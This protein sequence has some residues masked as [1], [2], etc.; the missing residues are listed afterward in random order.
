MSIFVKKYMPDRWP[1]YQASIV[2][3]E[4]SSDDDSDK[5]S[6]MDSTRKL[7]D[8]NPSSDSVAPQKRHVL[9]LVCY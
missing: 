2:V 8:A 1:Q 9:L 5:D 6:A 4:Q 3:S 7:S